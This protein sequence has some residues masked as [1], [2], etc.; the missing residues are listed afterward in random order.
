MA[1]PSERE[2]MS[3]GRVAA[4]LQRTPGMV[5]EASNTLGIIPAFVLNDIPHFTG[6]DVERMAEHF[7][8]LPRGGHAA[9]NLSTRVPQP[10]KLSIR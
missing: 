10:D 9:I 1:K 3:L 5:R 7:R 6:V 8:N 4:H 2:Y